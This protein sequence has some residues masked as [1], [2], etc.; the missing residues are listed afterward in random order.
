MRRLAG[1]RRQQAEPGHAADVQADEQRAHRR[2]R[3]GH[4]RR[5]ER[6]PQR[7]R[8]R[9]GAQ[10][11]LEHHPLEGRDR[12]ARAD[13]RARRRSPDAARHE[14]AGGGHPRARRQA[15]PSPGLRA[16][17]SRV[18]RGSQR[19][20]RGEGGLPPGPGGPARA[21]REGVRERSG[22][23]RLRDGDPDV[24]RRRV[25]EGLPGRAVLPRREDFQHLRG[26]EPYPGDGPRRPEARPERRRQPSGVSR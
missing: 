7:A 20:R 2:G 15:R 6:L 1:R 22:L 12:A 19:G 16:R 17:D 13:H 5:V 24:R 11:R 26:H 14:V 8:V 3:A 10:A 4:Q 9:Q 21:A 18:E 23:S 25:H